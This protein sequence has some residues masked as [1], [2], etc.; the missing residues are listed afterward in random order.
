MEIL[1]YNITNR[2]IIISEIRLLIFKNI[3]VNDRLTSIH[4]TELGA[5]GIFEFVQK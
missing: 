5:F 4:W 2:K 3:K 1:I